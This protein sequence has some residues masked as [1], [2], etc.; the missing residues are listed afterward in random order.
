MLESRAGDLSALAARLDSVAAELSAAI[1]L[2]DS[3]PQADQ[4]MPGARSGARAL[5]AARAI[6][7]VARRIVAELD[8]S[9]NAALVTEE[10][11]AQT[12][13]QQAQKIAAV[14]QPDSGRYGYGAI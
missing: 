9:A 8:S 11:F 7:A 2:G 1:K 13:A 14:W 5:S 6:D 12:D 3:A 4:A 10:Q